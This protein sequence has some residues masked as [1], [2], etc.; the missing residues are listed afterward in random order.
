ME[1][2]FILPLINFMQTMS[3]DALS[4]FILLVCIICILLFLR[5]FGFVGLYIY[6]AV[7]VVAVSIQV[8]KTS[9]FAFSPEPVALGTVAFATAYLVS[10]ILTEHYG[11]KVAR[12]GV[13]LSFVG[14]ILMTLMMVMTLGYAVPE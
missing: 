6:N 1:T 13:W 3:P 14:Q 4:L 8:L 9:T 5:L 10:D 7:I 2:S 12:K 11:A